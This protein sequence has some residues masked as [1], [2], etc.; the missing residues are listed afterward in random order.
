MGHRGATLRRIVVP[1]NSMSLPSCVVRGR[2]DMCARGGGDAYYSP[3]PIHDHD[4]N[5][6]YNEPIMR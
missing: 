5:E 6:N 4:A 3:D 1:F 2:P